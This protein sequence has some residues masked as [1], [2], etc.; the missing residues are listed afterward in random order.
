M[1]GLNKLLG[2]LSV[3]ALAG[4]PSFAQTLPAPPLPAQAS[5]AQTLAAEAT[6]E[7][8]SKALL[9]GAAYGKTPEAP[10][11]GRS[12]GMVFLPGR[13]LITFDATGKSG[14]ALLEA[15]TEAIGLAD[16]RAVQAEIDARH[17][18]ELAEQAA[19]SAEAEQQGLGFRA[20]ARAVTGLNFSPATGSRSLAGG[21]LPLNKSA[22][23][24]EAARALGIHDGGALK[25][26]SRVYMFG[27][28]SGRGV[29]MNLLH[30]TDG[31][32]RNAGLTSDQG[33]FIGQRQT[34]IAW[35]KGGAQAS[36]SLIDQKTRAQVL[37][38]TAM[39]DKRLMLSFSLTPSLKAAISPL[40]K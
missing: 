8:V 32:W 20:A 24:A 16:A 5:N 9:F 31:G 13:G 28:V 17:A 26:R 34:G 25:N 29:G 10:A 27:A 36:L 35:R 39:R 4:S 11:P 19:S 30:D 6:P 21:V 33:G 2:A 18:G 12:V 22:W 40:G 14:E 23:K 7:P 38:I 1:L 3:L 37:G 15:E